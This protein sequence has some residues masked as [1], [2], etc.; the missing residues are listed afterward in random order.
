MWIGDVFQDRGCCVGLEWGA[1]RSRMSWGEDW[2]M[3]MDAEGVI[4]VRLMLT[5]YISDLLGFVRRG[6]RRGR[7]CSRGRRRGALQSSESEFIF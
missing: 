3:E 6:G 7:R 1:G 2:E 4:A 5:D